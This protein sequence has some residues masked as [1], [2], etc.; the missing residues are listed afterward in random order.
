MLNKLEEIKF[1]LDRT[2]E[3]H[4]SWL[5]KYV[6][7]P[8][9]NL[10]AGNSGYYIAPNSGDIFAAEAR[11]T[12]GDCAGRLRNALNYLTCTVAEQDSGRIG[13][14]VQ[15]PIDDSPEIFASHRNTYLEGIRDEH[16]AAFERL[17]PYNAGDWIKL[18]QRLSN[19]YRH[20]G[21]IGVQKVFQQPG[22]PTAP[23]QTERHGGITVEVCPFIIAI[24]LEG[25]LPVVQT[26]EEIKRR[27]GETVDEFKPVL[28][29]YIAFNS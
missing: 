24:S 21:L 14:Q 6:I 9:P 18:L 5:R 20:K 3:Q 2:E 13:R 4:L 1:L 10:V 16:L 17:Q 8:D 22:V 12:I 26:L 27:V 25:G 7:H 23:A 29:R 15:F 28:A 11:L 19:W